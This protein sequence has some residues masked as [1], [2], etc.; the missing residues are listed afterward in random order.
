L[1]TVPLLLKL[2]AGLD[3]NVSPDRPDIFILAPESALRI[4]NY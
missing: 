4:E 2:C 1:E 3:V